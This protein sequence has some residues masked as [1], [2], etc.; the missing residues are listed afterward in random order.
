MKL[1]VAFFL[2]FVCITAIIFSCSRNP[3]SLVD[4]NRAPDTELWYAPA[5]STEY[6]WSVHLYW[7]GI[8]LDG[9][10]ERYIWTIQDTL[11]IG[12]LSWNPSLRVRDLRTGR[13]TERTDSIFS[14][15][16]FQDIGG[17]P[18]QKR[19]QAFYVASIDDNGVIDPTPA[20]IEFVA[21]V[22]ELPRIKFKTFANRYRD[23]QIVDPDTLKDYDPTQPPDTVGM[24]RPFDVLWAGQTQNGLIR[25]YRYRPLTVGVTIPGANVWYPTPTGRL[26]D[27]LSNSAGDDRL[28]V[29]TESAFR[30][31]DIIKVEDEYMYVTSVNGGDIE[32]VRGYVDS[33][34]EAHPADTPLTRLGRHFRNVEE[35]AI[36]SGIFRLSAQV[37]DD[38]GAESRVDA[39]SFTQGVAQVVV[40]FEPETWF[41]HIL[42]RYTKQDGTPVNGDTVS[43][44][45]ADPD[46]VP[47]RSWITLFYNSADSP[48]DSSVCALDDPDD[49]RCLRYQV[50]YVRERAAVTGSQGVSG[51][52]PVE[53]EDSNPYGTADSTSMNM[54]SYEYDIRVRA[55]D[56]YDKN[57][58]TP[59]VVHLVANY[60]P[61]LLDYSIVTHDGQVI[62]NGDTLRW[63]FWSPSNTDTL[64][65]V[66]GKRKKQFK[67]YI[68]G[69]GKDHPHERPGSG[70]KSW[71]YTFRRT[72]DPT[73][74]ERF[75]RAG[76]WSDGQFNNAVADTFTYTALYDFGD[77]NGDA[78]FNTLPKWMNHSYNYS[79]MGRDIGTTENFSQI[80]ILYGERFTVNQVKPGSVGRW[81]SVGNLRF[82]VTLER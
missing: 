62:Q 37:R 2:A 7:R 77:P 48:F 31:R 53:P 5:D 55:V 63:N 57:D 34:I 17:V 42:S 26:I 43:F 33:P 24:Y 6:T 22:E 21:T 15:T 29:A 71:L 39:G 73:I 11:T 50:Q 78:I 44:D 75:A 10:V 40:N 36:P 20:A 67:F 79:I 61:T 16:A 72:D 3:P 12:D 27:P 32:V 82:Y 70:V 74:F 80:M 8:D 4:A 54:G 13:V 18:L 45:P 68:N 60:D 38:A 59:P 76:T 14:F 23:G 35:G 65:G 66:I 30:E 49:N 19:R 28:N 41:T 46:T 81:T 69:T 9:T 64:D 1:R 47:F 58:G 56:E 52:L 25:S 51:W